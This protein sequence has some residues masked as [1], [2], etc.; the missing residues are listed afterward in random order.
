MTMNS[1]KHRLLILLSAMAMTVLAAVAGTGTASAAV[2]DRDLYVAEARAA[3]LSTEKAAGLQNKVD[4]YLTKLDGKGTQVA[5]N[6]IDL[7]GAVLNVAVP[8]EKQPRELGAAAVPGEGPNSPY[9]KPTAH[10]YWFCAYQYAN[11]GGDN[12]GMYTCGLPW[13]IPFYTTGSWENNQTPGTRPL[14]TFADGTQWRMPGAYSYQP[15]G[16]NWTPVSSIIAC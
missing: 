16:V 11:R 3:G 7:G 4:A 14:L 2:S 8:G 5:P 15:S 13:D 12:V 10:Y 1:L 9:C 6:Q